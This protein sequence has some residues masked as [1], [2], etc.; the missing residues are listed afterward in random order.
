[1]RRSAG[2]AI[3][4]KSSLPNQGSSKWEDLASGVVSGEGRVVAS[5]VARSIE[6]LGRVNP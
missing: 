6:M 1:M 3:P 4:N 2:D 5:R